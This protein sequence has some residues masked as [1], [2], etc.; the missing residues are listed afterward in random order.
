M[1]E[2]ILVAAALALLLAWLGGRA[3]RRVGQPAVIGE[4]VAGIALGPSLLG[5]V[6]PAAGTWLFGADVHGVLAAVGQFGLMLYMFGLG[7]SLDRELLRGAGRRVGAVSLGAV[8]VP[9]ALAIPLGLVLYGRHNVVGGRALDE[10]PFLLFIGTAMS[11]TAFPVLARILQD[12]GMDR[13]AVGT[14]ALAS[15]GALDAVGWLLL[16]LALT[17]YAA[18]GPPWHAVQTAGEAVGFCVV[19]FAVVRPTACRLPPDGVPL[20]LIGAV[21]AGAAT[22]AI[23]LQAVFGPFLFG[24]A[25][26]GAIPEALAERARTATSPVTM[27]V[28]FPLFFVSSGV[29]VNLW[30]LGASGL[31]DTGLVVLCGCAGKLGGGVLGARLG[32]L[33]GQRAAVIGVLM[34]TRGLTELVVLQVGLS[35]GLLDTSLFSALVIMALVTTT[36][37]TPLLDALGRRERS[38]LGADSVP[39]PGAVR[40]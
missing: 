35:V 7:L 15:A 21:A 8:A 37:T 16:V 31:R 4:I 11:I 12:R 2:R 28:L 17:V 13:S 34:N 22:E 3:A 1:T 6:W 26:R 33:D 14:L 32:G 29:T 36:M 38:A 40:A 23:H 10:L 24:V 30:S 19:L 39:S 27:S 9:L 20:L 5:K 18:G 25:V